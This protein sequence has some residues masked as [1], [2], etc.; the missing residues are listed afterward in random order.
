MCSGFQF[1]K[2]QA[3]SAGIPSKN[4][5]VPQRLICLERDY[6]HEPGLLDCPHRML[7]G[8]AA[9]EICAGYE[10]RRSP[11]LRP[12]ERK[13]G[14]PNVA[15]KQLTIAGSADPREKSSRDYSVRIN[16]V[17]W[18]DR[19]LAGMRNQPCHLFILA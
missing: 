16:V 5:A 12:I 6:G 1:N 3:A 9:S 14:C 15:K 10:D 18:N 2:E 8:G 19:D 17:S 7:T 13:I 11:G 4:I